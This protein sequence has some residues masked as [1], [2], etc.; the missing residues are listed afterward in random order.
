MRRVDLV[1]DFIVKAFC[2]NDTAVEN[3]R[4]QQMVTDLGRE[5]AEQI[6]GSKVQP[7]RLS[8]RLCDHCR[9]VICGELDAGSSKRFFVGKCF[10]V[11]I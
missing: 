10:F 3:A 8:D 5:C 11:Q 9:T 7:G 6:A 1:D 4:R 2:S